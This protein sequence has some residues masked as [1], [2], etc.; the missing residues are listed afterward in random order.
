M[1]TFRSGVLAVSALLLMPAL[2]A[3]AAIGT[4]PDTRPA[5]PQQR[6]S[7][8]TFG[9]SAEL[10]GN[11]MQGNADIFNLGAIV[12]LNANFGPHQFFL[13]G[14]NTLTRLA[15]TTVV[16]R[17]AGSGLYAYGVLDNFNLYGYTTHAH[18]QS[19]KVD[20]RLT[21]GVGLCLHKIASPVFSLFLLS[22]GP[23]LEQEWIKGGAYQTVIR[24]VARA[25]AVLPVSDTVDWGVDAF[26][27]PAVTDFGDFRVYAESYLQVKLTSALSLKITAADEYDSRPVPGIRLNDAGLFVGIKGEFGS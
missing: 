4:T 27:T 22:V 6:K 21:N 24:S 23:S 25:N 12:N 5:A 17:I 19:N 3:A 26:Y 13:D 11:F 18:D 16:N 9:A 2:P 14:G 1:R 8:K 7:W 10:S 15:G 20:Y